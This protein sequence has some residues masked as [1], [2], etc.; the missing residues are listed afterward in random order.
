M[1]LKLGK[2][3]GSYRAQKGKTNGKSQEVMKV[4]L[5]DYFFSSFGSKKGGG[6]EK[7]I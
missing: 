2:I 1:L 3:S 4:M 6:E 7:E 5:P